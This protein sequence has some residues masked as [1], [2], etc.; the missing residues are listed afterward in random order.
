MVDK[1]RAGASSSSLLLP[2]QR[3][4]GVTVALLQIHQFTVGTQSSVTARLP[5]RS[6][7]VMGMV[8]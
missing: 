5:F 1:G 4:L 7:A 2:L 6:L 3:G 8:I